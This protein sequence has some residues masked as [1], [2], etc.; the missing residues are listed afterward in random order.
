MT[1]LYGAT[2]C[3]IDLTLHPPPPP[4]PEHQ[5][6]TPLHGQQLCQTPPAGAGFRSE[7]S[8][9]VFAISSRAASRRCRR[10]RRQLP[11]LRQRHWSQP[12]HG[13]AGHVPASPC[14]EGGWDRDGWTIFRSSTL[15]PPRSIL[16]STSWTWRAQRDCRKISVVR[17]G[18]ILITQ[19]IPS[20]SRRPHHPTGHRR[21][22]PL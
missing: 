12:R 13:R 20:P 22:P 8:I 6:P 15:S 18:S 7:H 5:L 11:P 10:R 16:S 21:R 4:G 17:E 2:E 19:L 3:L 14:A 1:P 9:L